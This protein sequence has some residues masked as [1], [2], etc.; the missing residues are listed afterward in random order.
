LSDEILCHACG[1][2]LSVRQGA[3][4]RTDECDFCRADI[5]VCLQCRHYDRAS[6]NECS[7]PMAERVVDKAKRNFCDYFSLAGGMR[8]SGVKDEKQQ[9]LDKLNDLFKK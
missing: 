1:K 8:N 2:P 3:V 4:A 5:R 7:E 6:Y 9:A